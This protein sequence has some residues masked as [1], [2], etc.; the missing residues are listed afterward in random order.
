MSL[1]G[2]RYTHGHVIDFWRKLRRDPSRL[3]VLGNGKQQKSYLHVSDCVVAILTAVEHAREPINV[4]NLG[5]A[6]PSR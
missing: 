2:P 6:T 4:F 1:L 3:E 5:Q